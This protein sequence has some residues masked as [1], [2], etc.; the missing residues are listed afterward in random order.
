MSLNYFL[1][2]LIFLFF[3]VLQDNV[4]F[5]RLTEASQYKE[6]TV[7]HLEQFATEGK[8]KKNNREGKTLVCFPVLLSVFML[9]HWTIHSFF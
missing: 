2:I 7:A 3:I 6:L 4:I 8:T 5:E 9:K 1:S